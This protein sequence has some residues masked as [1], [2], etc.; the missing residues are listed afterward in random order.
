MG[1]TGMLAIGCLLATLSCTARESSDPCHKGCMSGGSPHDETP[2]GIS[3]SIRLNGEVSIPYPNELVHVVVVDQQL[4]SSQHASAGEHRVEW[5]GGGVVKVY[6][7]YI[8]PRPTWPAPLFEAG[9]LE[10]DAGDADAGEADAGEADAG[11]ADAGEADGGDAGDVDPGLIAVVEVGRSTTGPI[12][13]NRA[14]M[15]HCA[16]Q[17]QQLRLAGAGYECVGDGDADPVIE[18]LMGT[19][20]YERLDVDDGEVTT[21]QASWG[22]GVRVRFEHRKSSHY[23]PS[24]YACY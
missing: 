18:P 7:G 2:G 9:A 10:P 14:R 3:V 13:R 21:I 11:D 12:D 23:S 6:A 20:V 15:I 22:S 4:S 8:L 24:S 1:K 5:K 16:A 17:K 19:V